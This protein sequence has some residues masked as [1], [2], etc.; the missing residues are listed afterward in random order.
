MI[1]GTVTYNRS[2]CHSF[3]LSVQY[4]ISGTVTYNRYVCHSLVLFCLFSI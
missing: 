1:S 2:V 3:V 4:M